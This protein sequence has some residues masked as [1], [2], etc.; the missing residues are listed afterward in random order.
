MQL[1]KEARLFPCDL[2]K[3]SRNFGK[4]KEM[5]KSLVT[6][7]VKHLYYKLNYEITEFIVKRLLLRRQTK[8]EP[9]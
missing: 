1:P 3:Q 9:N 5:G 8:P 6:V 2:T 7:R 4:S